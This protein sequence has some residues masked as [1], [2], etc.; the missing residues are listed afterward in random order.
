VSAAS[1]N[2]AIVRRMSLARPVAVRGDVRV[3]LFAL[4][5]LLLLAPYGPQLLSGRLRRRAHH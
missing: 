5:L 3:A 2:A 4:A 1:A